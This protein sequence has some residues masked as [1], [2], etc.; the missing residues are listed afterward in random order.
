M[1]R[2]LGAGASEADIEKAAK[3]E[4][5]KE[6]K[7]SA[8]KK[9]AGTK[10]KSSTTKKK[11]SSSKKKSTKKSAKKHTTTKKSVKAPTA[12]KKTAPRK[13]D[14]KE[15]QTVSEEEPV[16]TSEDLLGDEEETGEQA[17]VES[18][19]QDEQPQDTDDDIDFANAKTAK[20]ITKRNADVID[21]QEDSWLSKVR[22]VATQPIEMPK[23]SWSLGSLF[24]FGKKKEEDDIRKDNPLL[25]QEEPKEVIS[26]ALDDE[27]SDTDSDPFLKKTSGKGKA[28]GKADT[29][30]VKQD[31]IVEEEEDE[32]EEEKPTAKR[33][34]K[35]V[36]IEEVDDIGDDELAGML[37]PKQEEEK[38]ETKTSKAKVDTADDDDEESSIK[39]IIKEEPENKA[40]VVIKIPKVKRRKGIASFL[41]SINNIGMGKE[42]SLFIQNLGTMLGAGLP[43][44]DALRTL[45]METRG[46]AMRK[47]IR[48]I[49]SAVENGEPLWR[50][51]DE[52]NL[53]SPH[54]LA[55]VRIGEEAGNLAENVTY[56]A[57]QDEKDRALRGKVKMAMIYPSIVL[58]LM[59]ILVIGLGM[60]VLPQLIGVLVSLNVELPFV[61]R[62]VVQ[63][64][65]L[66]TSYGHIIIPGIFGGAFL[67]FILAKFTPLRVVFQ[68][69]LF[70]VPGIGALA[71]EATIA[72][73][74]VILGGL[75]KAGVP[76]VEAIESL[77]DVTNI[78]S[79]RNFYRK[80]LAHV[81]GGDSFA[82]S[83]KTIRRA[84]KV[85]PPSVQQLVIVGERSGSLS[86]IMLKIADIY[87]K[88]ASE[89]AEKLPVILEPMLL[90]FIGGLVATIAFSIIIPIYSV[91]GNVGMG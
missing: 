70:R 8:S 16:L 11:S 49:V 86:E 50:A 42:R 39:P 55:L 25:K 74:G 85:L 64:S 41:Q 20:E 61:T 79:Y 10:K 19:Q 15:E 58:T 13:E 66:F 1:R 72:R 32:P 44:L 91:V 27:L 48:N 56:L 67:T 84:N 23:A 9:K 80:L 40:P 57:E 68:W 73:F 81:Q 3:A 47:V 53:F 22:N 17:V 36:K 51:M 78:V 59:I 83:F 71:K 54:A 6:K 60:F 5:K 37:R 7:S 18:V 88:K 35:E 63:F 21:V 52:Q 65:N 38:K 2:L 29:K 87:D 28:G 62:M 14:P 24:S 31:V 34:E 4:M 89:T 33:K 12:T 75:L 76:V 26:N 77:V 43:V 30:V 69:F 45:E 82:T 90:I 46:R